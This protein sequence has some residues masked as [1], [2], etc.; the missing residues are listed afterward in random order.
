MNTGLLL[1]APIALVPVLLFLAALVQCDAFKLLRL[2]AVLG[3][4]T[5]GAG[6]GLLR[7]GDDRGDEAGALRP[8]HWRRPTRV[9]PA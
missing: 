8:H 1:R 3:M 4:V 7:R 2:K 5:A 9:A 6:D